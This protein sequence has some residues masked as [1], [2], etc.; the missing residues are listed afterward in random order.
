M[1]GIKSGGRRTSV[2][3]CPCRLRRPDST[4]GGRACVVY[5]G[6]C[7]VGGRQTGG[8]ADG[9]RKGDPVVLFVE[10][11][12]QRNTKHQQ[13]TQKRKIQSRRGRKRTRHNKHMIQ[14][15]GQRTGVEW[16]EVSGDSALT[17]GHR[18]HSRRQH[19]TG[20]HRRG[21]AQVGFPNVD[22]DT[23]TRVASGR[24]LYGTDIRRAGH[25]HECVE[26]AWALSGRGR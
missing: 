22:I 14:S 18:G 2:S 13:H 8:W 23:G 1:Q 26:Q 16:V 4:P 24:P 11:A 12:C 3:L 17:C 21:R 25:G 15:G 9:C 6:M 7:R 10:A 19:R 5:R 20:G